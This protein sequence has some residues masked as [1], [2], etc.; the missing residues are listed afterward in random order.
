MSTDSVS[1]V[2]KALGLL[3]CVGD[4]GGSRGL[5]LA[6]LSQES[7]LHKSTAFR[8][9]ATLVKLGFL[10]QDPD[11]ERYRLGTAILELAGQSLANMEIRQQALPYL[12]DLMRETG[13][14]VHLG[15]LEGAQVIY[16][17][18]VEF[19]G[20]F[21]LHSTIGGRA[22]V[23]C[24]ALG[25]AILAQRTQE[26][27]GIVVEN[28]LGARTPNTITDP[29]RFHEELASVRNHGYSVDNEENREGICCVGAPIFDFHGQCNAAISVTALST[30]S[31]LEKVPE[32]GILVK[33]YAERIS[34]RMG[35]F[36]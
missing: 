5:A 8:H 7:G 13:Q 31:T 32:M 20:P 14:T 35:Y 25:K 22:P 26:E 9:A 29:R 1:S 10:E 6:E 24:T 4:K 27:I 2:E 12:R 11:T 17:E 33:D 23:H 3:R 21:R 30:N 18:K 36:R 15:I 34:Q 16:I 19:P 28:G